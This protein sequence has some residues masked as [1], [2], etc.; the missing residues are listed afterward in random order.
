MDLD[1]FCVSRSLTNGVSKGIFERSAAS[2]TH[3]A[4][5]AALFGAMPRGGRPAAIKA[6]TKD[7]DEALLKA[8]AVHGCKAWSAISCALPGRTGKACRERW[9]NH[10]NPA[11]RPDEWTPAEDATL[12]GASCGIFDACSLR[13]LVAMPVVAVSSQKPQPPRIAFKRGTLCCPPRAKRTELACSLAAAER[14]TRGDA[15]VDI[16]KVLPGRTPEAVKARWD[17]TLVFRFMPSSVHHG[18]G[19]K[20]ARVG[21]D[22]DDMVGDDGFHKASLASSVEWP[23]TAGGMASEEGRS[24]EDGSPPRL[25]LP[26]GNVIDDGT[27]CPDD[28]L[29]LQARPPVRHR[30]Q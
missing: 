7:E 13:C 1:L 20:R 8:V 24:S 19:T 3:A 11:L 17:G 27:F 10:L 22:G 15:W 4:R 28:E 9:F 5:S 26:T 25:C 30:L 18:G 12:F 2:C 23:V 29:F 21:W 16:A 6:W 14:Q